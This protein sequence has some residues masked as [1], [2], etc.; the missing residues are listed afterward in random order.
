MLAYL[1]L[2]FILEKKIIPQEG[3]KKL[4]A[5]YLS[6]IPLNTI[7]TQLVRKERIKEKE[8]VNEFRYRINKNDLNDN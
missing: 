8:F 4:L 6:M 1:P 7:L 2:L 3:S 5:C